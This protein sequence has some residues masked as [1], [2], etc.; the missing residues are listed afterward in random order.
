MLTGI[1][2]L[3]LSLPLARKLTVLATVSS[4]V[5]IALACIALGW[6]DVSILRQRLVADTGI[7]VDM[8]GANSTAALAFRDS[9]A[10]SDTLHAVA[11][12]D[13]IVAAAILLP[14]G[15]VLASYSRLDPKPSATLPI[16]NEA[17]NQ[18]G[19]WYRFNDST[20]AMTSPIVFDK[21]RVGTAYVELSLADLRSLTTTMW[22]TLLLA[23]FATIGLALLVGGRLQRFISGPLLSLAEITRTVKR[24]RR[25]DMRAEKVAN[26]EIGE[27]VDGF[28]EMLGD[29]QQRDAKLR[30]HRD[31][32]ERTVEARTAE[33]RSANVEL[34]TA[35]DKAL[36][37]S[38]AKSE[39]LA[40]MSHEIRTPMNGI[41]GMTELALDSELTRDQHEYLTTVKVSAESLM[42]IL[43]DILDFSKIES[44]K[45]ELESVSFP[46]RDL[47]G[48]MLKPLAVRAHQKGLELISDIAPEVPAAIKGDPVRLQQVLANLLNNAIK[49]TER[50]QVVLD[51]TEERRAEGTTLLHFR[52][53]DTGIGIPA[54][55]HATIFEAFSQADGSTTRRF[56]GTGLGLTISATLVHL[57]GGRVWVESEPGVGSTFHFTAGFDIAAVPSA[58]REEPLLANLPVLIVDD[59]EVNRHIFE[60]QLTRWQMKPTSVAGGREA[61]D[62]LTAAAR[63]GR[64]FVL[65]LLD[66]NMPEVD[67]FAVAK[68]IA[69]RP[70]LASATIMMLTSSGQYGDVSRCKDFGISSYLTKPIKGDDL[71]DSIC[72]VLEHKPLASRPAIAASG[73]AP[74]RADAVKGK[75]AK[76]LLAEDNVV[77]QRVAVGLLKR[78][79]HRVTV[80][81]NGREALAALEREAFDLVLMDVQMPEMG[82]LEATVAIR[83]RERT[84]GGHI[85]IVAM[86]AHAM[87]GDRERCLAAGMDGYLSKPVDQKMLY[88]VV[89]AG[90]TGVGP[91]AA[92]G[93]LS[94]HDILE[95]LGGD[96][97]L[98]NDVIGLF[99]DDCPK[100]MTAIKS[101]V[102]ARDPELI[103]ITAH[104][105]KGAAG[106]LSAG[107][108]FEAAQTLEQIGAEGRLEAAEAA[109]R[110]LSS[111][112]AN[113]LDTLRRFEAAAVDG[114]TICA[115]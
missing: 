112:A 21:E 98:F 109:W 18:S 90:S 28:N 47:I 63:A 46:L 72:R 4:G 71:L 78:R 40:N 77:N 87:N 110:R 26:D 1:K 38:R 59:N 17:L 12:N 94:R 41:I 86:T 92:P 80:A 114:H 108:L 36:E 93:S 53:I 2:R 84:S 95:R 55:K 35:R 107:G 82:G 51:I 50:G 85:R 5:S 91:A 100:R 111:E 103:R 74:V 27:L 76:V 89:E 73:P 11:V 23:M 104:A 66:A 25:Y 34:V 15:H 97:Q 3:F 54:E 43:N 49:F 44:R 24:D 39:F 57:M 75:S 10:A 106:N 33:L 88:A 62:A 52:V 113:V 101:A 102:D 8:V 65:V 48:E 67:G 7:L 31:D 68:E 79:G 61:L 22:R 14:D 20:L 81:S 45:L 60:K 99:L 32:L 83:E 37:A 30:S 58:P 6:F 69:Q 29:I 16:D 70:E 96:E 64:P 9:R 115:R 13:R 19:R 56:G 105:L 42:A